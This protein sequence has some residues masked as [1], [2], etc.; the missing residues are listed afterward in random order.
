M[1]I[2]GRSPEASSTSQNRN[3]KFRHSELGSFGQLTASADC[4]YRFDGFLPRRASPALGTGPVLAAC[5][6]HPAQRRPHA[7]RQGRL[8]RRLQR[9]IIDQCASLPRGRPDHAEESPRA[10]SHRSRL[11]RTA[12]AASGVRGGAWRASVP[13]AACA[14][15]C[16]APVHSVLQEFDVLE[17]NLEA[18]RSAAS[19]PEHPKRRSQ[20]LVPSYETNAKDSLHAFEQTPNSGNKQFDRRISL[21]KSHSKQFRECS[22]SMMPTSYISK[23]LKLNGM[24]V[25]RSHTRMRRSRTLKHRRRARRSLTSTI[26][27]P[28]RK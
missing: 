2:S 11:R 14:A 16:D 21:I 24:Q 26:R 13:H 3:I 27:Q 22:Q 10:T 19:V 28:K 15:L 1:Q 5:D 7:H 25:R 8:R 20:M 18:A 9:S 12:R 6:V 23:K 17:T 4:V